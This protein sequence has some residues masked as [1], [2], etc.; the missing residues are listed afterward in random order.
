VTVLSRGCNALL[1]GTKTSKRRSP[2]ASHL[3]E[4]APAGVRLEQVVRAPR[5]QT[6][7]APQ[8]TPTRLPLE[9]ELVFD[10]SQV[11]LGNHTGTPVIDQQSSS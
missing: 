3:N 8:H 2:G 6:R 4:F 11:M 10:P 7:E 5:A 1:F 9:G